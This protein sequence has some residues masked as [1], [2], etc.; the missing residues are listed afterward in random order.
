[1][2]LFPYLYARWFYQLKRIIYSFWNK[3][4]AVGSLP[5]THAGIQTPPSRCRPP[6]SLPS[7]LLGSYS[8]SPINNKISRKRKQTDIYCYLACLA[9]TTGTNH[10]CGTG[11]SRCIFINS[12]KTGRWKT[13]DGR[14]PDARSPDDEHDDDVAY[15]FRRLY[16]KHHRAAH[17]QMRQIVI[18]MRCFVVFVCWSGHLK[19]DHRGNGKCDR[20]NVSVENS[21]NSNSFLC[22]DKEQ[23]TYL[24]SF[25]LYCE[26]AWG[27]N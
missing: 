6:Q 10:I 18:S 17:L 7:T 26:I 19:K 11:R 25:I 1:M 8:L 20:E 5:I 24:I 14:R 4:K 22:W 27:F 2:L 15:F 23:I 16:S 21:W 12:T 3:Q 13:P 9:T